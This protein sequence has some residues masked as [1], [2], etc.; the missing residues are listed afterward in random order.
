MLQTLGKMLLDLADGTLF[1]R[2]LWH[3][4]G[5]LTESRLD[6]PVYKKNV[7]SLIERSRSFEEA[8]E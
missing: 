7:Q 1:L 4:T 5:F 3:G 8:K 6:D 2:V